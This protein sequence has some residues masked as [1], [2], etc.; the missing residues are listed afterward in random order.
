[1]LLEFRCNVGGEGPSTWSSNRV[2][3]WWSSCGCSILSLSLEEASG[4]CMEKLQTLVL[5]SE[6]D[7]VVHHSVTSLADWASKNRV[8]PLLI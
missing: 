7:S 4:L 5:L 3:L 8:G 1:M 2:A 6:N